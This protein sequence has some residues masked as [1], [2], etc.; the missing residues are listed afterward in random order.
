MIGIG[1]YGANG[2]QIHHLLEKQPRARLVAVAAF[3]PKNLPPGLRQDKSIAVCASLEELLANPQVQLVSLCSPRRRNQAGE[4]VR[5]LHAG[6][7]VYAEKP[8]AMT[9]ADLDAIL[10]AAAMT[11]R[12]FHGMAGTGFE[13][14]YLALGNVVKSGVLG[15]IIQVF[16]QKSYPYHA[17]R[18]QD[19]D[20][21]GG[22]IGQNAIHGVRMV[23]HVAGQRIVAVGAIETGC[24]NPVCGG[25]LRMAA[26]LHCT[27]AHGGIATVIANYLN[28]KG[29]GCWGNEHLR[30][31]GTCGFVEAVDGGTRTRLVV[32][33]QDRGPLDISAAG[34]DFF[35]CVL[36]DIQGRAPMPVS[37]EDELH[38]TRVVIQA[39][40]AAARKDS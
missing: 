18:P 33:E 17:G 34:V 24:G 38:P 29:M 31:F 15:E 13:Q 11:G 8:C 19:E 26:S 22:L 37:L 36:D 1:L 21:D 14:P 4:A 2:H 30:I 10:A 25:G 12:K 5:C 16:A 9:E 39:R 20:V 6:K 23:E 32:G 7:H 27:L 3:D 28:Q 40:L 35:G